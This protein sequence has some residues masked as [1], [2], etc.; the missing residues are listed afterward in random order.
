MWGELRLKPHA[1]A[2]GGSDGEFRARTPRWILK[3]SEGHGESE[4]VQGMRLFQVASEP[5][6]EFPQG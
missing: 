4:R 2:N 6:E 5:G 1:D 3:T